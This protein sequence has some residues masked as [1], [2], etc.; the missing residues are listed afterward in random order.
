MNKTVAVLGGGF[1][2]CT[3]ANILKKKGF[4]VTIF[5]KSNVLGGGVRTFF[6][7]GHPYTFGTHHLLI[8][9]DEMFIYEYYKEYCDFWEMD[10][11]NLS[12]SAKDDQFF[13]FPLHIEEVDDMSDAD[14]IK[15]ELAESS[16]S[17]PVDFEQYWEGR[18]GTTLYQTFISEY[19]KKMWDIPN[20]KILD[21]VSFSFKNKKEDNLK[22]GSKR[23]FDGKKRVFYPIHKDGY[24][25]YFDACAQ[26]CEVLVNTEVEKVDVDN[27]T[28]WVGGKKRK[29]DI[30]VS[31]LSIDSLF[32]Y[33]YGV[34]PYMG[35]EFLKVILP[36]ERVTPDPYFFIHYPNDEPFTRVFEYKLLTRH[37]SKN[38]LLGIEFPS[39]KNKLYPYPIQSEIARY[40]RYA[41]LLPDNFFSIGRLGRYHYDNQDMIIKDCMNVFREL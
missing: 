22:S 7:H 33:Q 30:V 11:Y 34:L 20:N 17:E 41:D 8:D 24:N 25:R 26:D 10:H 19:S 40:R 36:V 32:E 21:E 5:E 3:A 1:A 28:V 35:R 27:S 2:G 4:D 15:I 12:Y 13:T 29:F 39:K 14:R 16:D 18:V 9:V 37:K 31:T 38:T 6:Y 23:C